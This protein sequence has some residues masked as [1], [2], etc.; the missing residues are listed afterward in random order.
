M[1]TLAI[2]AMRIAAKDSIYDGYPRPIRDAHGPQSRRG[3]VV[4]V[5]GGILLWTA[6]IERSPRIR[7][8]WPIPV[9]SALNNLGNAVMGA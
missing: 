9:G 8:R 1:F 7:R 2:L 4:D 3:R 5:V 6:L